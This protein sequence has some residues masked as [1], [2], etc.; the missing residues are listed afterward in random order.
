MTSEAFELVA[1]GPVHA[2]VLSMLHDGAF[3]RGAG[4][5]E[6]DFMRLLETPGTFGWVAQVA[7]ADGPQPVALIIARAVVDEAEIL[8][9]G[10]LPSVRRKGLARGL[11]RAAAAEAATRGATPAISGSRCGQCRWYCV[12][13]C[14][15]LSR[16]RASAGLLYSSG[17]SSRGR[18]R[19]GA[20]HLLRSFTPMPI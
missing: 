1:V 2:R 7:S 15:G 17:R 13:P 9:I 10:S 18:H 12:V 6:G 16:S 20:R 14:A 11:V 5:S 19:H 3:G 4:W 8:T